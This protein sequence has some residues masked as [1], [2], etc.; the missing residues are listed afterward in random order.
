M[1]PNVEQLLKKKVHYFSTM[2]SIIVY[3]PLG[4]LFGAVSVSDQHLAQYVQ[5]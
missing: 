5:Q 4:Q 1:C 2:G 3:V